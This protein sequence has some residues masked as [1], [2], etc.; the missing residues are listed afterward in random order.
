VH[1]AC[2]AYPKAESPKAE[3]PKA[4]SLKAESL[5]MVVAR[6]CLPRVQAERSLR[7]TKPDR[8]TMEG[9]RRMEGPMEREARA[10]SAVA[11]GQLR[12]MEGRGAPLHRKMEVREEHRR[13]VGLR[14]PEGV[15]VG[16]YSEEE[17][18]VER[19]QR[20]VHPRV[21]LPRRRGEE[22]LVWFLARRRVRLTGAGRRVPQRV[23]QL[24]PW[25]SLREE[26]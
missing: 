24:E 18:P 3:S 19:R 11:V 10:Y 6:R 15:L 7:Q 2:P 17:G 26:R 9:P 23:I 1:P 5:R 14:A 8:Q 12:R 22:A 25:G 13:M 20:V 16:R 4:E 21:V